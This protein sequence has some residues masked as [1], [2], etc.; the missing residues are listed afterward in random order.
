ME[1]T[2]DARVVVRLMD[3][4]NFQTYR[5]VTGGRY[6]F[7]GGEALRSPLALEV[8][9][10]GHWHLALD[11]DGGSGQVRSSVKVLTVAEAA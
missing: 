11:F 1:V 3:E 10:P 7:V 4:S 2:V 9:H 8:P 5:G 6:S